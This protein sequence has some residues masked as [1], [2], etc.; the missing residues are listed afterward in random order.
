[1]VVVGR[2]PAGAA[3]QL[4]LD[5]GDRLGVQQL[6]Q[7]AG[8]EQLRQ[9]RPVE[10]QRLGAAL[11]HRRVALVHVGRDVVEQQRAAKGDGRSDSTSTSR[12]SPRPI[13]SSS[14]RSA[15]TSNTSE[16]SSR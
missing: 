1:M 2:A 13:R 16:S 9:Q 3:A 14:P 5:L 12:T 10:L 6:A 11:G 4:G 7:V 8:R 15:G